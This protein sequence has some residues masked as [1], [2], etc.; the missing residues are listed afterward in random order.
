MWNLRPCMSPPHTDP[1]PQT[2]FPGAKA[3]TNH[4]QLIK[5]AGIYIY[6]YNIY[7]NIMVQWVFWRISK[8]VHTWKQRWMSLRKSIVTAADLIQKRCFSKAILTKCCFLSSLV[9]LIAPRSWEMLCILAFVRFPQ[10]SIY[11]PSTTAVGSCKTILWERASSQGRAVLILVCA[12]VTG[13]DPGPFLYFLTT[14]LSTV[15]KW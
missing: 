6:I 2:P 3:V 1:P 11:R 5:A 10:A 4:R 9:I 8:Y 14:K 13:Q 7:R 12:C 15:G